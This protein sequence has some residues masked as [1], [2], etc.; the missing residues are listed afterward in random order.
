MPAAPIAR[1]SMGRFEV[2]PQNEGHAA[3]R[4]ALHPGQRAD[5]PR[6]EPDGACA[7]RWGSGGGAVPRHRSR[8]AVGGRPAA[9]P[10]RRAAGCGELRPL[11]QQRGRH[12]PGRD[13]AAVAHAGSHRGVARAV[14]AGRAGS[15]VRARVMRDWDPDGSFE[16]TELA[17]Q[18]FAFGLAIIAILAMRAGLAGQHVV[19]AFAIAAVLGTLAFVLQVAG[20]RIESRRAIHVALAASLF[21]AAGALLLALL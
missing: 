16:R 12:G 11:A 14:L 3:P 10:A 9:D 2:V 5:V 8:R 20:P 19:A 6:L 17:W 7:D 21:A 15:R 13:A 1:P 4:S 18:R